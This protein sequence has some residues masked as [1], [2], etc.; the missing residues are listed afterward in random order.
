[1]AKFSAVVD[2]FTVITVNVH[3]SLTA[4]PVVEAL[5]EFVSR[6]EPDF[7]VVTETELDEQQSNSVFYKN[8]LHQYHGMHIP[9]ITFTGDDGE[10][11]KHY[12]MSFFHSDKWRLKAVEPLPQFNAIHIAIQ[13]K[14]VVTHIVGIYGPPDVPRMA[15]FWSSFSQWLRPQQSKTEQFLVIGDMNVAPKPVLDR[16]SR[17]YAKRG[18]PHKQ[19]RVN[20]CKQFVEILEGDGT[21]D[22]LLTDA[23]RTLHGSQFGYTFFRSYLDG[24]SSHSRIDLALVSAKLM[25]RVEECEILSAWSPITYD[26]L[27]LMVRIAL[28]EPIPNMP[29][30][31][32]T[33]P[34]IPVTK[35]N[36]AEF[37]KDEIREKL[38][39]EFAAKHPV[40]PVDYDTLMKDLH[41]AAEGTVKP[42]TRVMNRRPKPPVPSPLERF[43]TR[44][45]DVLNSRNHLV[46]EM[47]AHGH[48]FKFTQNMRRLVAI[49]HPDYPIPDHQCSM[50]AEQADAWFARV[51]AMYRDACRA[52]A[53]LDSE[54]KFRRIL[55]CIE[56]HDQNE[57]QRPKLWYRAANLLKAEL[58]SQ[59][60]QTLVINEIDPVQTK[61]PEYGPSTP[62]GVRE[63][64]R[65]FWQR[66]FSVRVTQKEQSP[67]WLSGVRPPIVAPANLC[68][69]ISTKEL[70]WALGKLANGK[71]SGP[72]D[73]PAELLKAM[74]D[75]AKSEF[76]RVMNGILAG[77]KP[78]PAD[79]KQCVIYTI[80][81][82][83]DTA[84]CSNYRP[85]A[86]LS[87]PY[88]LF[89][90]V[91]TQ[92]L[93]DF[94]EKNQI[95]S[96]VQGG[97]R[98]GRNCLHKAQLLKLLFEKYKREGKEI[99]AC[100]I[101]LVK[102]YD[103]VPFDGL[104][105]SLAYL[106]IPPEFTLLL[107]RIYA[108]QT[109]TVITVFGNTD[110]IRLERGV[111]QGDPLSPVL[112]N[113]FVEPC[114]QWISSQKQ[115]DEAQLSYADD[116]LLLAPSNQRLQEMMNQYCRF[117]KHNSLEIGVSK[118]KTKTVY[119]TTHP[120]GNDIT[121]PAVK[122]VT[123]SSN[124][125]E[126]SYPDDAENRVCLPKLTSG[127]SYKYLGVWMNADLSWET[128][129]QKAEAK[130]NMFLAGLRKKHY[131]RRQIA[132]IIN[133]IVVPAVLYGCE[134][135]VVPEET[136]KK[137]DAKVKVLVN[138][139]GGINPF[140]IHELNTLP[141]ANLGEGVTSIVEEIHIRRL[142]GLLNLGLNSID[143]EAR[144]LAVAQS[145]T[146]DQNVISGAVADAVQRRKRNSINSAVSDAVQWREFKI[147]RNQS[148]VEAEDSLFR[149]FPVNDPRIKKLAQKAITKFSDLVD[150]DGH[151]IPGTLSADESRGIRI[152][153][154]RKIRPV[155]LHRFSHPAAYNGVVHDTQ[156]DVVRMFT[157]GS[158]LKNGGA[159]AAVVSENDQSI[160]T[161]IRLEVHVKDSTE[162]E[163]I[164]LST[165]VTLADP[166]KPTKIYTDS[167]NAISVI[168]SGASANPVLT[169]HVAVANRMLQLNPDIEIHHVFSHT[170]DSQD[171]QSEKQQARAEA[172]R[173]RFGVDA[174]VIVEGNRRADKLAQIVAQDACSLVVWQSRDHPE[175]LAVTQR[176]SDPVRSIRQSLREAYRAEKIR[177]LV[178]SERAN[179]YS[180]LTDPDIDWEHS[181]QFILC[182]D[183]KVRKDQQFASRCRRGL[184]ADMQTRLSR[185][186]QPYWASRYGGVR[187]PDALCPS[188]N[189]IEDRFHFLSCSAHAA[190]RAKITRKVS[191]Q[192]NKY[193][194]E[195]SN[196]IP[197][198]WD[199]THEQSEFCDYPYY[200]DI[201][202]HTAID[203][204]RGIIPKSFY[205]YVEYEV[206][207]DT[208]VDA[209]IACIQLILVSQLRK[210]W[211]K[212]CRTLFTYLRNRAEDQAGQGAAQASVTR[213]DRLTA[214]VRQVR[215]QQAPD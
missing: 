165:A 53:Q 102:A 191:D 149:L 80:H 79:W 211:T 72:D 75:A 147:V 62:E 136:V 35:L 107:K 148:Y 157:D 84:C 207:P 103:S 66:I 124:Q 52:K 126:I 212:R 44:C 121:M 166:S 139:K 12:G 15:A 162:T 43:K 101:D 22:P 209:L 6:H 214:K 59:K 16:Q 171:A 83:G 54:N 48:E 26:H 193:R 131:D 146:V 29:T 24:A 118:S 156:T 78:V 213:I 203:A 130:L 161:A 42:V 141:I 73:I 47:L 206:A 113:L 111:H 119:M 178:T 93:T 36:A 200:E 154:T 179:M 133:R 174:P 140:A 33:P 60:K 87:V 77:S 88:K 91:L 4:N 94:V 175:F 37:R 183:R 155:I 173:E 2:S 55:A 210:C 108:D 56:R 11:T 180:W 208:D 198:F 145:N 90:T 67:P 21:D 20:S 143:S 64:I 205:R 125:L 177:K 71:A 187:V 159:G 195:P 31:R 1:M 70:D 114:L 39:T 192:L 89:A 68:A 153:S 106:Q 51:A 14:F 169:E 58:R 116:E 164:A 215:G 202:R 86:L 50:S 100:F 122:T 182:R 30:S 117:G 10:Q 188:C 109:A 163:V 123:N 152:G 137:W 172:N 85:I 99:H 40:Q 115:N 76:L 25:S 204:A 49:R 151:L 34:E 120:V 5:N 199:S 196:A 45:Q 168:T 105:E 95:I 61:T 8:L 185:Q 176:S 46:F 3:H 170:G 81:K 201:M 17:S 128:H 96:N 63:A 28:P 69:E 82:S 127:E 92:R 132:M 186:D 194:M 184:F 110:P 190:R 144:A 18:V 181:A 104:W 135:A 112:F 9:A 98:R 158:V 7:L 134:V 129:A 65:R 197:A 160:C 138:V 32:R 41:A 150:E 23:W 27:P 189:Q 74:P 57:R 13:H 97:F 38:A 19:S 167:A 142:L